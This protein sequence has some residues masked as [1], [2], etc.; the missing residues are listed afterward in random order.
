MQIL[1]DDS[2]GILGRVTGL[3]G[4]WRRLFLGAASLAVFIALWSL[5]SAWLH[6][7]WPFAYRSWSQPAEYIPYP[8][9]VLYAFV[10]SFTH[11]DPFTSLYMTS[12]IYASLK[13]MFFGFVLAFLVAVPL[14]LLMGRSANAEAI[15]KPLV[16]LFRPIPPL[17]WVPIFLIALKLFWGPIAIVFLG[18]FFPILLNVMFG[19][20]SVDPVLIDAARTLGAKRRDIFTKVV[21][22]FTIPYMMTGIKVGIGVG[23]M[24][25]VAAEMLG[26]VGGGVGLFIYNMAYQ[27][28]MYD[29]MYAGMLVIGLLSVLTTGAAG[30]LEQRLSRWMG[31]K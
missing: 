30:F 25:I 23:W 3:L 13:R 18:I 15:G 20:K 22:P 28:T 8:S 10:D 16:E 26:A 21:L 5:Y 2:I 19:A 27:G 9:E 29:R 14:G 12:H 1:R 7:D 17:A 6:G 31:M 11:R 4:S 24:C